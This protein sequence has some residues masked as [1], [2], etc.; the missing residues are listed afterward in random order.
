MPA[1]TPDT[2]VE[3]VH[4]EI[5]AAAGSDSY[6]AGIE[7]IGAVPASEHSSAEFAAM[8]RAEYDQWPALFERAGITRS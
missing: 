6:R 7:R 5:R 1:A 8:L 3:R 2:V 4:R